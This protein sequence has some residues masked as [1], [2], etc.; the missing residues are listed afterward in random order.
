MARVCPCSQASGCSPK[1]ICNLGWLWG[2]MTSRGVFAIPGVL[3]QAPGIPID[4]HANK[5]AWFLPAQ[6]LISVKTREFSPVF[7]SNFSQPPLLQCSTHWWPHF[8]SSWSTGTW[9]AGCGV[10]ETRIHV[11]GSALSAGIHRWSIVGSE[12]SPCSTGQ[13]CLLVV[14]S[15]LPGVTKSSY[16]MAVGK[17]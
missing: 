7:S 16:H 6:T 11:T 10:Q 2:T 17:Y 12:R 14:D 1:V 4:F 9:A 13:F 15:L 3:P 5:R 8:I